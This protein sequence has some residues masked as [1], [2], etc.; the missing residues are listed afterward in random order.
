MYI[1]MNILYHGTSLFYID[2][3]MRD[4]ITGKYPDKLFNLINKFWPV[5]RGKF[6][7]N[8]KGK[9]YVPYFMKR[10]NDIRENNMVSIS[11]TPDI[12]VA[13][14]YA[15]GARNMGEGPGYFGDMLDTVLVKNNIFSLGQ[16]FPGI[17][18]AIKE[19]DY[20]NANPRYIRFTDDLTMYEVTVGLAIKRN[21]IY[22]YDEKKYIKLLSQEGKKYI[23]NLLNNTIEKNITELKENKDLYY[24]NYNRYKEDVQESIHFI[25]YNIKLLKLHDILMD[26]I[27]TIDNIN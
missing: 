5:V 4:G 6:E 7:G 10:Q 23:R 22:I 11:F 16:L 8:H 3:I 1:H 20:R 17:I 25:E 14:E 13:K 26:K 21:N 9:T 2:Y 27:E 15:K 24:E 19:E 12:Q 18:L